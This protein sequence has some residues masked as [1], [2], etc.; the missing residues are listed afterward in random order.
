VAFLAA[1]VQHRLDDELPEI[2]DSLLELLSPHLLAP[3]PSMM[4]VKLTPKVES[5]GPVKV[6]RGVALDTEP[7]RGEALRYTTCHETTLWP[8]AIEQVRLMGLPLAAPANP[9]A[10]GAAACL[11]RCGPVPRQG[12]R[13]DRIRN[14]GHDLRSLREHTHQGP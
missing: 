12:V 8:L 7:V 3:V 6:P 14:P 1:R 5:R 9:R 13:R 2:T 10:A 11:P 4:T